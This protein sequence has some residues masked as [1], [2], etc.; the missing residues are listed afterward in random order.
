MLTIILLVV[1]QA[2]QRGKQQLMQRRLSLIRRVVVIAL[3]SWV[4][5][6]SSKNSSFSNI[7]KSPISSRMKWD[8]YV[9][10]HY[11]EI[12]SVIV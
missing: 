2:M 9:I 7:L 12:V 8:F 1:K 10:E 3:G 4:W 11:I 6:I 5:L